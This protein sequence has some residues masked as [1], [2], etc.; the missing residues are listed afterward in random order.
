MSEK[1]LEL[2]RLVFFSD[3]VVAI[4]ITLLALDLKLSAP[5]PVKLHFADLLCMWPKFAAFFL[6]F[7]YIAVF[8]KIHHQ[9]FSHI[10]KINA[11]LLWYNIAWLLFIVLLP[12]TTSL[13]S[14]YLFDTPAIFLYCLN[15]VFLT[16]L[17][18]LIWDYVAVRPDFLKDNISPVMIM[19]YIRSCNVA[20]INALLATIVCFFSPLTAFIILTIRLP[21][22]S[23][24]E[25]FMK[26]GQNNDRSASKS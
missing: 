10:C 4:A 11:R 15:A 6:S 17:Q 7:L 21:M 3:A 26:K 2:E 14:S 20:M 24:V 18:N 5:L 25:L 22:I 8:W 13:L 1:N 23:A 19:A 16:L 9:F 12:F